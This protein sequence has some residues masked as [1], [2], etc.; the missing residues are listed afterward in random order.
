M[1]SVSSFFLKGFIG[2]LGFEP[3]E[4]QR[5]TL[6]SIADF[7]TSDET[8]M[9]VN[10]YAGTGKTTALSAVINTLA[11]NRINCVLLAPTGRSAKVLSSY[12][13]RKAY[14]IHKCIYKQKAISD[15]GTGEFSLGPNKN[16]DT[17]FIVDEAS[18]IG[19]DQGER[20]LAFGT[21]NLLEDLISFVG[22]GRDCKLIFAGDSA[23]LPP[24]GLDCSPA[25][26]GDFM[27]SLGASRFETLSTVVRQKKETGILHNATIIRQHIGDGFGEMYGSVGKLS[28]EIDGFDDVERIR[29]GELIEKIGE[30]YGKYGED[31]TVILCRSNKRALRYNSGIRNCVQFK[32]EALVR[33][34]RL[35]IAKNCY[36]FQSEGEDMEFIANGDMAR[37]LRISRHE[38]RYGFHFAEARLSFP[39]YDDREVVAKVLL[40]TLESEGPA[41]GYEQQN[42]LYRGVNEDY[43]HI[44]SKKKRYEAVK[45]DPYFNAL[46]L[47]YANA[48]TCH[49]SQGGQW[50]CVFIDNPFWQDEMTTDDLKWLYTAVTRAV[51]KVYFVNFKDEL[52][53]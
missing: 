10:G 3:T 7:V 33:G 44:T 12:T 42:A 52:F 16:K 11:E 4:C 34:E 17:L 39:D 27:R 14:T 51:S 2:K 13:G 46:Q 26:N 15:D 8:M 36:R 49:K 21:G 25:L 1:S 30:A 45:E 18:L 50:D 35:M 28:L 6:E 38:T 40:D 53:R 22:K 37:L 43:A 24:V 23:Q 48:L 47:K 9:V 29:G 32:E 20:I 31:S 41:L 19:I 5:R